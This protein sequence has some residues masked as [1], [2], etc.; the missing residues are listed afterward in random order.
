M[1]VRFAGKEFTLHQPDGTQ[2]AVRG[3]GDQYHA[4]FQTL[5]GFTVIQD[6]VSGFYQY[7]QASSDHEDLKPTGVRL[8]AA[9]PTRL[10]LA[11]GANVTRAAAL[12]K[13]REHPGMPP[14]T[15]RWEQRRKQAKD[16]LR[17]AALS[18]GVLRA[19][20]Q[21]TTVGTYVGLCLCIQFPDVPGTI[22]QQ[23]VDDFCNKKGYTGFGNNGS[24]RDYFSDNSLGKLTYT[25]VVAP[26]YTAK[27][28]RA[29]YTDESVAQPI[30]ARQL[31][32]EAL[33]WLKKQHFDFSPLTVDDQ[34]YVYAVNCF[35]AGVVSNN[36]SKGLWP[37]SYH[38]QTPLELVPGKR[39]YDYQI[40]DFGNELTLGTFCHENGHM[41]CDYP[42]LYDYGNQSNGVGAWSLMCSGPNVSPKNPTMIDAYLKYKSGWAGV[43][44]PI[45]NG[46]VAAA[47]ATGN[48]FFILKKSPTEYYIVENRNKSG[49]DAA[50]PGSGLAIW[51]VDEAGD[52]NN[53]EMTAAQHY[54]LSLVQA[55]G[56]ADLE[57]GANDG[58]AT[59]LYSSPAFAKFSDATHPASKWWDGSASKLEISAISAS[60][61]HM[62]FKAKL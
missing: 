1:P 23:Q 20:P 57:H 45:S 26:Y 19:P 18:G 27:H 12:A 53:E 22:S 54:E 30:R 39:A 32:K 13:A 31:I 14:G 38:L 7:A 29:Y 16:M 24:V 51:H 5:D 28:P 60:G 2:L 62:T 49:R 43:L 10:G 25:S 48:E 15:S 55:D 61:P 37:H 33:Q 46:L 3:W 44:T 6:P 56:R 9:D 42:D 8:G 52:Q 47:S 34:Q 40:T 17:M 21:R 59:D 35:Y 36:W 4:V 41:I 11:P 50:L 58:D